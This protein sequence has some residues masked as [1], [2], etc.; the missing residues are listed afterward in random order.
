MQAWVSKAMASK[1]LRSWG[2]GSLG[3]LLA[4][5]SERAR[6]LNTFPVFTTILI[7]SETVNVEEVVQRHS[8]DELS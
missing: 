7:Q 5:Y 2:A 3:R 8:L 4:M 6:A 1:G